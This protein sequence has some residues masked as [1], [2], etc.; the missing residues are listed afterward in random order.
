M[1]M[2]LRTIVLHLFVLFRRRD[3][4]AWTVSEVGDISAEL[5]IQ[6]LRFL[7]SGDGLT[8][9]DERQVTDR[10]T[11]DYKFGAPGPFAERLAPSS[12]AASQ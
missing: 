5:Q 3:K 7:D 1:P 8:N 10:D 2:R 12:Y 4:D 6:S 11:Y 9:I